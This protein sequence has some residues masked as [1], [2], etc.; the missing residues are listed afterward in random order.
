[1]SFKQ[2]FKITKLGFLNIVIFT[3]LAGTFFSP[4]ISRCKERT[5]TFANANE[6]NPLLNS[7]SVK[8]ALVLQ[9]ALR[10]IHKEVN[11]AVVRIET[12]QTV[13]LPQHPF[14]SDPMFRRFF[15]MPNDESPK[16]KRQG[17]GS[18]FVISEDG[19]VV[20]NDHVVKNADKIIVKMISGK[21]FDAKVIGADSTSDIALIKINDAKNL[22]TVHI[23]DSDQI[24]VGDFAIAIGNP[25]GLSSTFTIGVIS[26]KGQD[27]N[28]PDGI[29]RIQTDAAINPGNSGGPLLNLKGEVV[30][31]NQMIYS[32]SGGSV[33][34]GFAIPINYAVEV[35][36]RLKTGKEIKPGYIGV[37]VNPDVTEEQLKELNLLGKTGLLVAQVVIGSP[38]W[39]AGIRPYDFITHVENK[40]A[41]KFSILKSAVIKK[42]VGGIIE[43]QLIS[44]GKTKNA[45]IKIVEMPTG[46]R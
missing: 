37:S 44:E 15:G 29:A 19:Y 10:E 22:K 24:E 46:Y 26:S 21:S 12:E 34:I 42:G 16:Q 45:K 17:L 35:L 2:K 32:Q 25:F 30:G 9:D 4:F 23:G 8:G 41:I 7:E 13:D 27:I 18:G 43:M 38:A 14:F 6:K 40:E 5:E 36:E 31:I 39:K 11:P 3:F 28:T 20:T 1:M 33:G